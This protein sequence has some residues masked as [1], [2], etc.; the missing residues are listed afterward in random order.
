MGSDVANV[1]ADPDTATDDVSTQSP[2]KAAADSCL[3]VEDNWDVAMADQLA[4]IHTTIKTNSNF[5]VAE[6]DDD[7]VHH[8]VH[9]GGSDIDSDPDC[10]DLGDILGT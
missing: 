10:D 3:I 7:A 9:D 8:A 2:D 6:P 1:R 5:S 4:A